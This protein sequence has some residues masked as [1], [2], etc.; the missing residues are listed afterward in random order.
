[1]TPLAVPANGTRESTA[2]VK[3]SRPNAE[4][5]EIVVSL[6]RPARRR[7][8]V[9]AAVASVRVGGWCIQY[10]QIKPCALYNTRAWG[11]TTPRTRC[12]REREIELAFDLYRFFGRV[13]VGDCLTSGRPESPVGRLFCVDRDSFQDAQL[14]AFEL[15]RNVFVAFIDRV[16][17]RERRSHHV[18]RRDRRDDFV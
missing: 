16:D 12:H 11:R 13:H 15:A 4:I 10:A 14:A 1:M 3:A 5:A 6:P 9:G 17:L 2:T 8:A 18:D 7:Q